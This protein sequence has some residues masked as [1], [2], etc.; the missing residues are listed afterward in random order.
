MSYENLLHLSQLGNEQ[1]RLVAFARYYKG[2]QIKGMHYTHK[3][4]KHEVI[5]INRP[6]HQTHHEATTYLM[7]Q[8]HHLKMRMK[9]VEGHARNLKKFLDFLLLWNLEEELPLIHNIPVSQGSPYPIEVILLGYADYL[10]CIPNGHKPF[11]KLKSSM[12]AIHWA[13]L[14]Q[15]PLNALAVAEGKVSPVMSGKHNELKKGSWCEF[16]SGALAPI[17]HT[18]CEYLQFLRDRTKRFENLPIEQIPRKEIREKDSLI[19]GITG[20][21]IK[22]V[23]DVAYLA[24]DSGTVG[25]SGGSSKMATPILRSEVFKEREADAFFDLFQPYEDAQDRLLFG[26]LRYFGLRPGEAANLRISP[27]SIPT[28][29]TNYHSA[30][31]LIKRQIGGNL[32]F[33]HEKGLQGN[34]VIDT[35]WKT[36]SSR[37][38][39][40]LISH[41]CTDPFTGGELRFPTQDEFTEWLYWA[42]LQRRELLAASKEADHGFLFVS[43]SN[44]SRGKQLSEK[45][46][47]SKYQRLAEKLFMQS[48]GQVDLRSYYPHTFRHLF[49][50]TLLL[51]YRRSIEEISRWLG[52]S[53][54]AVTRNTYIHWIPEAAG[55]SNKGEITDMATVYLQQAKISDKTLRQEKKDE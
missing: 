40:P 11:T 55:N 45:G 48:S 7:N 3:V 24:R 25:P 43:Q 14:T 8:Q 37:R 29:L 4:D 13:M 44:N 33:I 2:L 12:H 17:I 20:G 42:I 18:A 28:D 38:L 26:V 6:D 30:R 15:V 9:T 34:W 35:G 53:S 52:H 47:Y 50:T 51:R 41:A 1:A 27:E 16:P 21:R 54:V 46:V 31:E 23:F 10:R 36:K 39:V 49:A 19:S 32:Q 22:I 5:A